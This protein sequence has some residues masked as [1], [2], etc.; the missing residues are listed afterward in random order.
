MPG[1]I[2][3]WMEACALATWQTGAT[4]SDSVAVPFNLEFSVAILREGSA[5]EKGGYFGV[6]LFLFRS[7]ADARWTADSEFT[8]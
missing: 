2:L 5:K 6:E 8:E 3:A 7:C 1:R 4:R